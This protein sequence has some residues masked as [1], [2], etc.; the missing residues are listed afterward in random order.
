MKSFIFN[1]ADTVL[2]KI[3]AKKICWKVLSKIILLKKKNGEIILNTEL[4]YLNVNMAL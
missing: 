2:F 4:L 1:T 3:S